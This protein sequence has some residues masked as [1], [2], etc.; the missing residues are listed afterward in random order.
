M[1]VLISFLTPFFLLFSFITSRLFHCIRTITIPVSFV[2]PTAIITLV[3]YLFPPIYIY[4][5]YNFSPAFLLL[6]V[7]SM[8]DNTSENW[9]ISHNARIYC[10]A[11][12][13]YYSSSSLFIKHIHIVLLCLPVVCPNRGLKGITD[14]TSEA[15]ISLSFHLK[16]SVPLGFKT[17]IHSAN[18]SCISD[19][20]SF[21][22]L[23]YFLAIHEVSP[24]VFRCG[25]TPPYKKNY[26]QTAN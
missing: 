3:H 21:G 5:T 23:P 12:L 11:F 9:H 25:Q 20:Q 18:P 22:S 8:R 17:R 16:M 1:D 15:F 4:N 26:P 19:F 10:N 7:F 2:I 14:K 6:C 13:L 24:S